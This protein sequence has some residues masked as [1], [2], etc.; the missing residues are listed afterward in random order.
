M[1]K[2]YLNHLNH[3][4]IDKSRKPLVLRGARQVGKS[5]LVRQ[6]AREKKLNFYEINLE[7]APLL[8]DVFAT[9]QVHKILA[10]LESHLQ[11]EIVISENSLLFLDE[12]QATPHAL[13]AL[14]YFYEELPAI[15]VIAA[16]SL[17][18]FVLADHEFSMPVGRIEYL[19]MQPVSFGDFLRASGQDF[20]AD[21][22]RDLDFDETLTPELHAKCL[23][24]YNT[25]RFVGGMPE[26]VA[27]HLNNPRSDV[28]IRN[29]QNQIVNTY[30]DDF[31]KYARKAKLH[32]L[33]TVYK[34]VP[35]QI[36]EKISYA[37]LSREDRAIN[38]RQSVKMLEY[39]RVI[40]CVYN[41]PASKIPIAALAD[42][43]F[44]KMYWLDIGLLNRLLKL[45]MHL[46]DMNRN[47]LDSGPIAEQFVAQHL[48]SLQEP[49]EEP[50][51]FYWQRKGK[52]DG[53]EVDFVVQ[54]ETDIVPIEV[55][56]GTSGSL[57]SLHQFM[58]THPCRFAVRL[59]SQMPSLN[60]V[61]HAVS[62]SGKSKKV[63]FTLANVPIYLVE[64]LP[65]IIQQI[66]SRF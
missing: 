4:F 28:K 32:T 44:Y 33:R 61:T 18:E 52:T 7:K 53:A 40:R 55:K 25:Y 58:A 17:L 12:I 66:R 15:G 54:Y 14:R 59:S 27:A 62:I 51:L 39:A 5:T 16:G 9:L 46:D 24:L 41:T 23:E 30:Q 37:N 13:A 64:S 48:P 29:I 56:A 10:R 21:K 42:F 35:S 19:H 34:K 63:S 6:F 45:P 47:V 65:R 57:R 43:D 1:Q 3:W 20:V 38:V 8:D 11:R 49:T 36:G 60:Q 50:E 2:K 26:A 22:I 31:M